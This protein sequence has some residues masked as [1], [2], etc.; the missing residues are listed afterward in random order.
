MI[1]LTQMSQLVER[2]R[3]LSVLLPALVAADGSAPKNYLILL[4]NNMELRPTGGFIG[5]FAKVSFEGGKLKKL[6]VNDSYA[7]DGQLGIHVEPPKE[8]KEDLGQK[9]WFMRDSNW[10]P[11][12]PTSA[13]QQGGFYTKETA[14]RVE[15]GF[16]LEISALER[17]IDRIE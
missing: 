3:A 1:Y 4:Q 15:G 14:E 17:L 9:D 2:A 12:F 6:D 16:G 8:I 10:E 5:S 13:R 11:D 7:I